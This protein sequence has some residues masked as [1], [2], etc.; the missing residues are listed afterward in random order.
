MSKA[1]VE[2]LAEENR[3]IERRYYEDHPQPKNTKP[4]VP[5]E[6]EQSLHHIPDILTKHYS[7]LVMPFIH[8]YRLAFFNEEEKKECNGVEQKVRQLLKCSRRQSPSSGE[9]GN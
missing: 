6:L 5:W 7:V 8:G 2:E 1:A 9:G 3:Q 4:S